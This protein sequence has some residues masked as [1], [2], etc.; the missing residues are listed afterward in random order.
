MKIGS[1]F[2]GIGGLDL[3]VESVTRGRVVWQAETDPYAAAV[4][5]RR[6]PGVP[7]LGDVTD[8]V[9]PPAVDVLCGGFPCQDI[10]VAGKRAG[11]GGDQSGLWKDF[12]RIIRNVGPRVVFVENV[13]ALAVRGLGVVLGD[14]AGLGFNAE[15]GCVSACDVGATHR[16]R[17]MWILADRDRELIREFAER[18]QLV[19]AERRDRKPSDPRVD[20]AHTGHDG[21]EGRRALDDQHGCDASWNDVDGRDKSLVFPPPPDDGEG[22]GRWIRSGRPPP[23]VLRVSYGAPSGMDA[24]RR[25]ARVRCLGNAV[26]PRQAAWAFRSLINRGATP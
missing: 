7:N 18:G 8:I 14:L 10:S 19:A 1:L 20:L 22:W 13:A 4:L 2:S 25:R 9:D 16:R 11:I 6:W 3:A 24:R 12:A 5:A 15:W 23:G 26:V 21:H 17:R